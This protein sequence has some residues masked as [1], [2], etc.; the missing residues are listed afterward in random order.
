MEVLD[1]NLLVKRTNGR[2]ASFFSNFCIGDYVKIVC[3]GAQ[4]DSYRDAFNYFWGNS[5][6]THLSDKN[7][8]ETWK[9]MN[10]AFHPSHDEF[11]YYIRNIKGENAVIGGDGIELIPFH[12]RNRSNIKK[13]VVYQLPFIS[14]SN[15]THEWDDKLWDFYEDNKI[16]KNKRRKI[17][18]LKQ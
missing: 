18:N 6:N 11:I 16:V 10:I 4:Y 15:M 14:D 13:I 7:I 1:K 9:V 2:I 17:Y 3:V 5:K 8:G 12:K